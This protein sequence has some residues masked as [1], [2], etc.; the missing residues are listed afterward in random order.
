MKVSFKQTEFDKETGRAVWIVSGG[1]LSFPH[2]WKPGPDPETGGPS[3]RL[4]ASFLINKEE[5]AETV[6]QIKK[7]MLKVAKSLN[8]K[9][10]KLGQLKHI[11]LGSDDDGNFILKSSNSLD[12][13]TS[14]FD[15]R[16]KKVD[17]PIGAGAESILYAGCYVKV[18][19]QVNCD[20][21]ASKTKVWVNLAAIQF[22]EDGERFGGAGMSDEEL[23]DGFDE[24]E[25]D[26]EKPE[27]DGFDDDDLN[28]EEMDLDG[29]DDLDL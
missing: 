21:S 3:T 19:L 29:D 20:V 28:E 25:G 15:N 16:G 10:E 6:T 27:S 1:R 2:L 18:K 26:F 14:Y 13:P 5:N 7:A 24:V 8:P 23:A 4:N 12:R 11:K 22:L 9:V 17:D